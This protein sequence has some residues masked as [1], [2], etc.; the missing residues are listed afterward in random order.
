MKTKLTR[1]CMEKAQKAIETV[2]QKEGQTVEQ[3]RAD[4]AEAIMVGWNNPEPEVRA[5]WDTVPHIGERPTPEELI[6]WL[7]QRTVM[8]LSHE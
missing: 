3:I 7:V 4:M 8:A 6:I 5:I 1:E 2:A